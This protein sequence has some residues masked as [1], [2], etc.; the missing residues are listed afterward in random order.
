MNWRFF[1]QPDIATSA[2]VLVKGV[3]NPEGFILWVLTVVC[4][5]DPLHVWSEK[6]ERSTM[7]SRETS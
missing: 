6:R 3:D 7:G 1:R 2:C 4:A 5:E